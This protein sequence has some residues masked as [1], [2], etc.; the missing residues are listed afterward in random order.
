M[1]K[2]KILIADDDPVAQCILSDLVSER[3]YEIVQASDGLEA[4]EWIQKDSRIE[5]AFI[6]WMMPKM[7]GIEL[8]KKVREAVLDRYIYLIMI[9]GKTEKE[10]MVEGLEAGADDFISKPVHDGE[11]VSRLHAGE[12]VLNYEKR[13][14]EEM[15]KSDNLLKNV[16]PETI[17]ERMKSGEVQI[18]DLFES[19]SIM[20]IDVAG[21]TSWC[22]QLHV[23]QMIQELGELFAIFDE[24]IYKRGLEKIKSIGD[25]YLVASGVPLPDKEHAQKMAELA[26]AILRRLET[27]NAGRPTPWGLHLGIASGPIVAGVIGDKRVIYDVW[28]DTVNAASRLEGKAGVNEIVIS[29]HTRELLGDQYECEP[30]GGVELK[31]I[32]LQ[33]AWR[34][35][36]TRS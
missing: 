24:E 10:D 30:L 8:S 26:L 14:R 35:K 4:W 3:G 22:R 18:S 23:M 13:V 32:G 31:G 34:L 19:A 27:A 33:T 15:E 12:R 20:F 5:M 25:A 2:P 17:A 29:A 1:T 7:S 28:G 11:L 16:L 6:D 36:G 9:T 21:F